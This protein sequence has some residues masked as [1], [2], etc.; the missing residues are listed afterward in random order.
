MPYWIH[1]KIKDSA[2]SVIVET[3]KEAVAKLADLADTENM[4]VT[5]KD[6]LGKVIDMATL[7]AEADQTP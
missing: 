3:A 6:L 2:F 1:A 5:A 7:Q 4:E